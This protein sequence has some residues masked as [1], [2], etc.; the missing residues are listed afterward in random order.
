VGEAEGLQVLGH[1]GPHSETLSQKPKNNND[2]ITSK[3]I[4]TGEKV[5]RKRTFRTSSLLTNAEGLTSS[6]L[7]TQGQGFR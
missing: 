4:D 7:Y 2:K 1:P 6:C 3:T 5:A